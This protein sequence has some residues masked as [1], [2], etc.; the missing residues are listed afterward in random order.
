MGKKNRGVYPKYTVTRR[1]G[2]DVP[3]E[4]HEACAYFVLDIDHDRFALPALLAYAA[5]CEVGGYKKLADDL[6]AWVITVE[7]KY[8]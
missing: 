7:K 6:R 8:P 3:G 1:D 2:R 4:K 5:A